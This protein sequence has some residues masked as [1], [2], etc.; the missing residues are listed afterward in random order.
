MRSRNIDRVLRHPRQLN[1]REIIDN[2]EV[3]IVDGRMGSTGVQQTRVLVMF[4]LNLVFAELRRQ[5]ERPASERV[6]VC[7]KLDEGHLVMGEHFATALS[8]LR[9]AGLEATVCYQY[10]AQLRDE[11]VRAG[12]ASLLASRCVFQLS[13][14]TD[15]EEMTKLTMSAYA[16]SVRDDPE[17]RARMG[18]TPDAIMHLPRHWAICSWQAGGARV[19]AFAMNTLPLREDP[20]RIAHHRAGQRERGGFVPDVLPH[21]LEPVTGEGATHDPLEDL[22]T[23]ER[24]ADRGHLDQDAIDVERLMRANGSP[25][26]RSRTEPDGAARAHAGATSTSDGRRSAGSAPPI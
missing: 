23:L 21:P 11:M 8:T 18:I 26:P 7:L 2:R 14:A 10:S 17:A 15:A 4:L 20:E 13:E 19:A 12:A 3:L 9:A 25:E 24:E 16:S 22:D 1:L 5:L 6:R